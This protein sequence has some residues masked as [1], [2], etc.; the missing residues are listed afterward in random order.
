[1]TEPDEFPHRAEVMSAATLD[2]AAQVLIDDGYPPDLARMMAAHERH[3]PEAGDVF[4]DGV[5]VSDTA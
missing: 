5:R 3:D 2:D 1:M 4:A